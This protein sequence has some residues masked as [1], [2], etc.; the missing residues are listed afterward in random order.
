MLC[1]EAEKAQGKRLDHRENTGGF[2]FIGAWPPC[3]CF[4]ILSNIQESSWRVVFVSNVTAS[5]ISKYNPLFS[6]KING[7]HGNK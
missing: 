3:I 1:F 5:H 4:C 6:P 7:F 2:D